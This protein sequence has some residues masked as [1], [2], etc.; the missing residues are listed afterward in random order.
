MGRGSDTQ[1]SFSGGEW[2][3]LLK[4]RQ[5]LEKYKSA[6]ATCLNAVPLAQGPW[7]RRPGTEFI[8]ESGGG[9][10]SSA[11]SRLFRF[12]YS[13]TQSYIMEASNGTW[14]P[15][16]ENGPV[17]LPVI[18][19]TSVTQANPP[20]VT[21]S[22]AHGYGGLTYVMFPTLSG[23]GQLRQ[24]RFRASN[25]TANTFTLHNEDLSNIDG[26]GFT[27]FVSG[28]V[29]RIVGTSPG[30]TTAELP[31]VRVAQSA[32]VM[33]TVHPSYLPRS[34]VRASATTFTVT[35]M[36]FLD[37]PYLSLNG[38][39]TTLTPSA[40][41]GVSVIT[42]SG[43]A[44]INDGAGF[45]STDVGRLIR[46]KHSSTWGNG[47]I[48]TFTSTTQVTVSVR[49][50]FGATTASAN[51]RLGLYSDTTGFPTVIGF[52]ED[53]VVLA[54]C[55]AAPN[56]I[57][58]SRPGGYTTTDFSFAPSATDGTVA[59][60]N[61]IAYTFNA[62]D[63]NAM[64]WVQSDEKGLIVGT[65]RGEWIVR[66]STNR[67]AL[68]PVNVTSKISTNRGSAA[69][70]A[71]RAGGIVLFV[72]RGARKL[73]ELAWVFEKDSFRAPDMTLL[74]EHIT[75]PGVTDLTIQDQPQEIA[76][77][78]RSDGILLGFTYER[79]QGVT[80]WH[81]H[82][83]GG[84]SDAAGTLV[85]VVESVAT[86]SSADA[87]REELWMVVKRY[88][89]GGTKRYI[90]RMTKLWEEGDLKEDAFF[91]DCGVTRTS[92]TP[93]STFTGLRHLEGETV[94]V[95]ADGA[96]HNDVVVSNAAIVLDYDATKVTVGYSYPSDG[97]SMPIE[98]GSQ[99][100]TAQGK[101]KRIVRVGFIVQDTLGL[102]YG[103]NEDNL[104][105]I[106]NAQWGDDFGEPTELASGVFRGSFD[107]DYD[108]SGQV[109]WRASGPFPATI[110]AFLPQV[111]TAD[112]S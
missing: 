40:T 75:S 33:F 57:D 92:I 39:A 64:R 55:A 109:F 81:R 68:T 77:A 28:T 60:D 72:Q 17:T 3:P 103:P 4:G 94:Q 34:L 44:G 98:A 87:S 97:Q 14:W 19:V 101:I 52:H 45:K 15:Y 18:A 74:A 27:A 16:T 53:R 82:E 21:T 62:V 80:A 2:S 85:P 99:D 12:E 30:Y 102:M 108:R 66:P 56:R 41:T 71:V 96:A 70:P 112:D 110:L 84:Q 7:T 88:V 43:T 59:N 49:D 46:I 29:A 38:T 91:L 93:T 83:L 47:K 5:D 111:D 9:F 31:N 90:E 13:T 63:A 100:G 78:V 36:N 69:I 37:G 1:H 76:W 48:I 50:A 105:E 89:N 20:V 22:S 67:E 42:A 58:L 24:R 54:G 104:V 61:A 10:V 6:L 25:F 95:L 35:D 8:I 32:D 11:T 51:W 73:R 26:T 107:G 86:M 106:L 23:M 79:D 65:T